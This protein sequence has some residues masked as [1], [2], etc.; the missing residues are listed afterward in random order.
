MPV[1]N[2]ST[3]ITS[4]QVLLAPRPVE[5]SEKFF[6]Q[7]RHAVKNQLESSMTS[8][9]FVTTLQKIWAQHTS[10]DMSEHLL[11]H[12]HNEYQRTSS[13]PTEKAIIEGFQMV[14]EKW[15]YGYEN[16]KS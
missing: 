4:L 14:M 11:A 3:A 12:Q 1:R 2:A 16:F 6:D 9:A 13:E 8:G 5:L 15:F 10:K 7:L